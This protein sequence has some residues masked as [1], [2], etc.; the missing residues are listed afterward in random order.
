MWWAGL[1]HGLGIGEYA[2]G[3]AFCGE[4]Y[5]RDP[6]IKNYSRAFFA[7]RIFDLKMLTVFAPPISNQTST[8]Q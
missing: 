8:K 1:P 3:A 2:S 6:K 4:W 5:T 7:R